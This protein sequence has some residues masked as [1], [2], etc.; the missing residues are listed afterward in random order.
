MI[1]VDSEVQSGPSASDTTDA[2]RRIFS[3]LTGD[4]AHVPVA[5]QWA[6]LATGALE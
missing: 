1:P 6:E 5:D 4:V 3:S 2:W